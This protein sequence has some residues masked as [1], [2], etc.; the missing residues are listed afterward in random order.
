M[1]NNIRVFEAATTAV[2]LTN[3]GE[4]AMLHFHVHNGPPVVV[5]MQRSLLEKL[6]HDIDDGLRASPLLSGLK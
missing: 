6:G 2:H 1:T 5:S 4:V 3:G